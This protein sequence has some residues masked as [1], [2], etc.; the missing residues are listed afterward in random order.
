MT[1]SSESAES[2]ETGAQAGDSAKDGRA[3]ADPATPDERRRHV[4]HALQQVEARVGFPG[5]EFRVCQIRDFC[6]GGLFLALEGANGDGVVIGD[7]S[8]AADDEVVVR[9]AAE[10]G[11]PAKVHAIAIAARVV[12][13]LPGGLGLAF[14]DPNPPAIQ[15]LRQRVTLAR[16]ARSRESE[17]RRGQ[18]K[19]DLPA[20]VGDAV[21]AGRVLAAYKR[22]VMEFFESHLAAL[23]EQTSDKLWALARASKES[24]EQKELFAAIKQL[25]GLKEL[26]HSAFI[27]SAREQLEMLGAPLAGSETPSPG[28][29]PP[30]VALVDTGTFEDWLAIQ[31]IIARADP[32]YGERQH[33]I[34]E[35]LSVLVNATI[36]EDNDPVGLMGIGLTFHEAVQNL[37]AH[38]ATR[39]IMFSTF[40]GVI[41]AS[42]GALYDDLIGILAAPGMRSEVARSESQ[43]SRKAAAERPAAKA[44]AAGQQ[45]AAAVKPEAVPVQRAAPVAATPPAGGERAPANQPIDPASVTPPRVVV[46]DVLHTARSLLQ[47][48]RQM[49][50]GESPAA[51]LSEV[52]TTR[53]APASAAHAKAV[54]EIVDA[55]S[56]LQRS[57][58]FIAFE[59]DGPLALKDRLMTTWRAA[60]LQIADAEGE[61]VEVISNLLDAILEDPLLSDG[62]RNCVRRLAL[63]LVKVALQ[64]GFF[65]FANEQHAARGV[66]NQLGR[67]ELSLDATEDGGDDWHAMVDPLVERILDEHGLGP[68]VEGFDIRPS[69]FTDVLE[70]L[71]T[72]VA[73]Q[74][75]RYT[76]N[77]SRVVGE[78]RQQQALLDSRRSAAPAGNAAAAG[79]G[80]SASNRLTQHAPTE[81][82]RWL[83]RVAQLQADDVVYLDGQSGRSQK[84]TLAWV[85]DDHGSFVFVDASGAKATTLTQQE[86]AMHFRRG[87]ARLLDASSLPL[88]DRG[89]YRMLNGL[90][91]RLASK[92]SH[93]RLTGLL[94]GKAFKVRLDEAL[95][96]AVRMGS[97]HVLCVLELDAFEAIVE[98]CGGEVGRG[99]LGKLAR[100]LD[101][102][103]GNKGV[104]GR[105]RGGRFGILLHDC[106]LD[107]GRAVV[108]GQRASLESSRCVW[109]GETFPLTLSA[110]IVPVEETSERV[111]ALFK[112]AA[113]AFAQARRSGGNRIEARDG[114][115]SGAERSDPVV[116]SAMVVQ[117]LENEGL[118]LRCQRVAAIGAD[119]SEQPHYEI[120][121]GIKGEGGK[122]A[123]PGDFIQAAERNDQ[124]QEVDR[125]VI[126]T[127]LD[128]M[129]KNP[130]KVDAAGGYSINLSEI[131]L[132]DESLLG[133]VLERFTESR[134]QP[135]KVIF[136]VAE[137]AAIDTLSAAVKFIGTLKEHGCRFALDNFGTG[138]ASFAHLETLPIDYVKIDGSLVKAIVDNPGDFALVKSIN[139]IGHFLDKK[140]VAECVENDATLVRLRQIGVDYAQGFGIEAPFPLH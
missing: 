88:V 105:L 112:A 128:W 24:E 18:R 12:R 79:D 85:S 98:K 23:F 29:S 99:L 83:S 115:P 86:L 74:R 41:V 124:M 108:D 100:V 27:D 9:F 16:Q 117:M 140:T 95:T 47:L 94:N 14:T 101:K 22:R 8:L 137:S 97:S 1:T 44:Q 103:V 72:I 11:S 56:V 63:P 84:L 92:A 66:L 33:A 76:E 139:E 54:E 65:F 129:A 59:E 71:D 131:T 55:L 25:D 118:Q 133:Y 26:V 111:S 116:S 67:V 64:D 121:L 20:A 123:L 126:R 106:D 35:R 51:A 38:P 34:E 32:R 37:G 113:T 77:V 52:S 93:D 53:A 125:W 21:G 17:A 46:R 132:A 39:K 114:A 15:A 70:E 82:Q 102:Q 4:R 40:E 68:S 61:V 50:L 36:D 73:R 2:R 134:V 136:E 89:I 107:S 135:A 19:Q 69:V 96:S 122:I 120:L 110:G 3:P 109:H 81:W 91:L 62:V 87:T 5:G 127:A 28:R 130:D 75:E 104:I 6:A 45:P 7:K 49:A 138:D 13:V 60:G 78:R 31:D 30:D 57:P 42:L 58:S 80:G 43:G 90:H 48:E 119:A 10:H